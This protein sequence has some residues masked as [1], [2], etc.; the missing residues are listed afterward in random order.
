MASDPPPPIRQ[1]VERLENTVTWI[2]NLV[3]R[4]KWSTLL[5]VL[6]TG[7]GFLFLPQV[8]LFY[9]YLPGYIASEVYPAI[10]L[11]FEVL[12][13][14]LSICIRLL[15]LDRPISRRRLAKILAF[16]ITVTIIGTLVIAIW[17]KGETA[18]LSSKSS[19][20]QL[21]YGDRFLTPV[22]KVDCQD[23][24]T[25][26]NLKRMRAGLTTQ[27][28]MEKA[29]YGQYPKICTDGG[30]VQIYDNNSKALSNNKGKTVRVAVSVPISREDGPSD[31]AEILRGVAIAQWEWNN[32]EGANNRLVV[33]IVDDRFNSGFNDSCGR[34]LDSGECK[35]ARQVADYLGKEKDVLA[36]IGH[37]SS[38]AT[39]AAATTYESNNL[40]AISP[41][42]T[43]P[44]SAE[45]SCKTQDIKNAICLNSYIFRAAP[46][47]L[48]T[49]E[50]FVDDIPRTIKKIVVAYEATAKYSTAYKEIFS[51]IFTSKEIGGVIANIDEKDTCSFSSSSRK[52][53]A[54][55]CLNEAKTSGVDALLLVP[56]TKNANKGEVKELLENNQ[57]S[58]GLSL[59]GSD[60]MYKFSFV[61]HTNV[62]DSNPNSPAKGM[63][64][65][66]PWI[67][68]TDQC[69]GLERLECKASVLF[70]AENNKNIPFGISWRT[71]TAYDSTKALLSALF[72]TKHNASE[73][74]KLFFLNRNEC[75]RNKLKESLT[76]REFE[77]DGVLG[78]GKVR[79]QNGDRITG[80][81]SMV[82]AEANNGGFER[83][84][85]TRQ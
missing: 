73:K 47:D 40:V 23:S 12:L 31:S 27:K 7:V 75:L 48:F 8:G 85:K 69:S 39:A 62:K 26:E 63:L 13:I 1:L 72:K 43:T 74:C 81:T 50:R 71:A 33:G 10:F 25:L 15:N 61:N 44:R 4:G 42:S 5:L 58:F 80:D 21:S 35:T 51:N 20:P 38:D 77:A 56:T 55:T 45:V 70:G 49:I 28:D 2:V 18:G 24:M 59:L 54:Q 16:L 32:G 29:N 78:D 66:I 19:T 64:V 6:A 36:V 30:E 17:P 22:D 53:S 79:F 65:A 52:F 82:V 68:S 14:F 34:N 84:K 60:S 3:Q 37:F 9:K 67:K 11:I 76:D 46:N 41:T 83:R 57:A